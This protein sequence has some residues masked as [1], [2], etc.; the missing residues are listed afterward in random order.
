MCWFAMLLLYSNSIFDIF[1]INN[2]HKHLFVERLTQFSS[3]LSGRKY[4]SVV[5]IYALPADASYLPSC[6][7]DRGCDKPVESFEFHPPVIRLVEYSFED[8]LA[9]FLIFL[10]DFQG[11]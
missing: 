4:V 3:G 2:G 11:A 6:V 10:I 7:V 1:M 9:L 8:Y 5:L